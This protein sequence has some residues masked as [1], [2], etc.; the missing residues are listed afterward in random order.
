MATT[1][2]TWVPTSEVGTQSRQ[3]SPSPSSDADRAGPGRR[4]PRLR[5][6][7]VAR[8]KPCPALRR[9]GHPLDPGLRRLAVG[10]HAPVEERG[11]SD[12]V[13]GRNDGRLPASGASRCARAVRPVAHELGRTRR[14]A[15]R[16]RRVTRVVVA[17]REDDRLHPR[18]QAVRDGLSGRARAPRAVGDC[19]G[20]FVASR[21][22]KGRDRVRVAAH[23]R[24]NCQRVL[25]L[26]NTRLPR[27][28]S[29]AH[30]PTRK[31]SASLAPSPAVLH[32]AGASSSD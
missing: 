10:A 22:R 29:R 15:H 12:L 17:R 4:G 14:T 9:A 1:F 6:L 18:R 8:R 2:P 27:R 26:K 7:V 5:L 30:A 32:A 20:R 21:G 11:G 19:A 16:P 25:S 3:V 31:I 24:L 28:S 23:P 13:S